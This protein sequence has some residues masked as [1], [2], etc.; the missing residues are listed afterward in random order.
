[1]GQ[2]RESDMF[3]KYWTFETTDRKKS[4]NISH[5]YAYRGIPLATE[6]K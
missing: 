2:Q 5:F 1:M 4:S 6:Y 3:G